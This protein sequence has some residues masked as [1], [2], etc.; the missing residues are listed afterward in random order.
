M[1]Q[2]LNQTP[3]L[4]S[5]LKHYWSLEGLIVESTQPFGPANLE[6]SVVELVRTS[7]VM[8][9]ETSMVELVNRETPQLQSHMKRYCILE[10]L[11]FESMQPFEPVDL[12]ISVDELV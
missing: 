10:V 9:R 12:E 3:Q 7:S 8:N 4:Q 11:I 1:E 5:Q 6:I 2:L